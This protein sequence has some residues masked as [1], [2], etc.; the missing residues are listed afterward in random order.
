MHSSSGLTTVYFIRHGHR[1]DDGKND[2]PG[3]ALTA[4]GF[5]QAKA[6][7]KDF[8]SKKITIDEIYV[9]EML[10]ARQTA[11]PLLKHFNKKGVV[12]FGFNEIDNCIDRLGFASLREWV[13]F[14]RARFALNK[15]LIAHRG[16]TIVIVSH[17][18]LQKMLIGY[19]MRLPMRQWKKL[20]MVNCGVSKLQ[21]SGTRVSYLF[22]LNSKNVW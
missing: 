11:N 7:A 12:E 16:K 5:K 20:D 8:K 18:R 10:R 3:P 17:G 13:S 9:S 6:I 2:V 22:Y 4:L 1:F 15:L 21:F 19:K 14:I